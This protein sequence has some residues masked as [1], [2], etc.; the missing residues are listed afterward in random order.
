MGIIAN[1]CEQYMLSTSSMLA[2]GRYYADRGKMLLMEQFLFMIDLMGEE[3][4]VSFFQETASA[5]WIKYDIVDVRTASLRRDGSGGRVEALGV[6]GCGHF[7][8][9]YDNLSYGGVKGLLERYDYD[10]DR[11]W[12]A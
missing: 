6:P 10:G 7:E 5:S 3:T 12:D 2:I 11:K 4:S 8:F 1:H 9:Y